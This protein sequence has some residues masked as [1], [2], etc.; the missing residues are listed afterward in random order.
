MT[1][2]KGT[3]LKRTTL[4]Q[5][6]LRQLQA[7]T[8]MAIGRAALFFAGGLGLSALSLGGGPLPLAAF[9]V[10]AAA[11]WR[12]AVGALLG[13]L[14]G[15]ALFYGWRSAPEPWALCLSLFAASALLRRASRPD[16]AVLGGVTLVVEGIFLLDTGLTPAAVLRA[17]VWVLAALAL[18][19][20]LRRLP[21]A[22]AADP[23]PEPREPPSLQA[24]QKTLET[25]YAVLVREA[26]APKTAQLAELFDYAAEQVCGCCVNREACWEQN[27]ED[28]YR[29]L[30]AAGE[31]AV[32]RGTALRE[33]LPERF[34]ARCRHTEGFLTA[35][36]QAL[37]RALLQQRQ[38][39]RLEQ[40]RRIAAVQY[41]LLARLIRSLDRPVSK[42]SAR[43]RPELA[44]GAANRAGS[45]VSG[46][47]GAACRD[48]FGRFYV[49]LCDGMGSGAEARAESD[50]AARSLT[51]FLELGV[52]A[53]CAMALLNG[54]FQLRRTAVF[55]TVDLLR[56]DLQ[57]GE[58][59]LYK[60]GAAP[61]Y[62]RRG[63]EVEKIGTA[64]LPPGL[65]AGAADPPGQYALSLQ[66]GET[67]VMVSDGAYGEETEHRLA[68]M[69]GSVRDLAACLIALG[70]ADASDDRTVAVLRL[71][72]EKPPK[73]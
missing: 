21:R 22:R 45:A 16:P 71:H 8:R 49:L 7:R 48:R 47:R 69:T 4:L 37:D 27:A 55:S 13:A 54:F 57:T 41:L 30:C 23:P 14:S 38:T 35:V 29:D 19:P 24:A 25:M 60:W 50:R 18:P 26:P 40:G 65:E 58:G 20:V 59:I 53:D 12:D 6:T 5:K 1:D 73:A 67:L 70:E 68:E 63:G 51:A 64:T 2:L 34:R 44:V 39:H 43:F 56:L 36:N 11:L 9:L 62:L 3:I 42:A 32:L 52:E 15:Y 46:D 17:A 28:T 31:A 10:Y 33:D 66:E 61:S 72:P